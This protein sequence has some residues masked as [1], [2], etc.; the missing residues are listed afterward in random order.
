MKKFFIM[1]ICT[2][3]VFFVTLFHLPNVSE[4]ATSPV[5][6]SKSSAKKA[7]NYY[8]FGKASYSYIYVDKD[9]FGFYWHFGNFKDFYAFCT[10]DLNPQAKAGKDVYDTIAKNFDA[11]FGALGA[12][13]DWVRF[14][15]DGKLDAG[16][17]VKKGTI[18]QWAGGSI[19]GTTINTERWAVYSGN[20]LL[21]KL[22]NEK[23]AQYYVKN[24]K[25]KNLTIKKN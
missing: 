10:G 19:L 1:L 11:L 13:V 18:E 9:Q 23:V 21:I 25:M 22:P 12:V 24:I 5:Y 15:K 14:S 4:A 2:V 16:N 20:T 6:L 8:E 7:L 17:L 3:F